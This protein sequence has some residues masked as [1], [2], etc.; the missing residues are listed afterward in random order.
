MPSASVK[1][2]VPIRR[3]SSQRRRALRR[4]AVIAASALALVTAVVVAARAGGEPEPV[5][6]EQ[7]SEVIGRFAGIPQDGIA[8]G[9]AGAPATLVEFADLQCPFCAVYARDVL[10]AVLERYV[11]PGTLRLELNVLAFLG[12]DS[13][14][15]GRM[16]AAAA[17]QNR[18]WTFADAFYLD[19]GT[20]NT[21]YVTDEFLRSA[22]G[23]AGLDVGMALRQ[24]GEPAAERQLESARQA[25]D[26]LGVKSTPSFYVRSGSGAPRAVEP[27]DLTPEAFIAAL[28]E[29]LGA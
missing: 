15:A 19:Q 14:R 9:A 25:A 27:A 3:R 22:G 10:P 1:T 20:E 28:D 11:R 26:R 18:L 24:R 4:L 12:E 7:R 2:A 16:A 13:V 17:R 29:A 5:V 23:A 21:G 8:L 6:A